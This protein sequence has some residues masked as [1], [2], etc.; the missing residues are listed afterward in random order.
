RHLLFCQQSPTEACVAGDGGVRS[1]RDNVSS[2]AR[3]A[4]GARAEVVTA[5][6]AAVGDQGR[7]VWPTQVNR[8]KR[9]K[10]RQAKVAE[11]DFCPFRGRFRGLAPRHFAVH[12][13]C[14]MAVMITS[15]KTSGR[16]SNTSV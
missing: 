1:P 8:R 16:F 10:Q 14:A 9:R 3:V 11:L 6:T 12:A 15:R 7:V 4:I 13:A 2:P 5:S